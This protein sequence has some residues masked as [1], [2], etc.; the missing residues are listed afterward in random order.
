MTKPP[1]DGPQPVSAVKMAH[2]LCFERAYLSKLVD[3]GVLTQLPSGGFDLDSN[4]RAYIEFL[5]AERKLHPAARRNP[6]SRKRKLRCSK[7]KSLRKSG[8]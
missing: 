5:R 2:H 6:R 4:R 3:Q 7:S 8:T 1:N